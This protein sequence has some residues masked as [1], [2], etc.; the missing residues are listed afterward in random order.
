[1][2]KKS[3]VGN[4]MFDDIGRDT[5]DVFGSEQIRSTIEGMQ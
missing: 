2:S 3:E 5:F 1:M 4:N